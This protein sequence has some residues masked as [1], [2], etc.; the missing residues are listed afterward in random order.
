MITVHEANSSNESSHCH[1]TYIISII[2][3]I[4]TITMAALYSPGHYCSEVSRVG[5]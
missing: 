3:I 4:I 5:E 2:I 1:S